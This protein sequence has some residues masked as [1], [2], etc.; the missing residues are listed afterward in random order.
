M[1][2]RSS[3]RP[4]R[5]A[6]ARSSQKK[7]GPCSGLADRARIIDL[8]DALMRG[9]VAAALD[10]LAEQYRSGADPAVILQELAA[11]THLVTR[12]K[13][14]SGAAED[15]ALSPEERD[16]GREFASKLSLRILS[17]AWQMLLKGI[18]EAQEAARPLAAA[19]MVLVRVAHAADLPTP[20]EALRQLREAGTRPGTAPRCAHRIRLLRARAPGRPRH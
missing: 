15:P 17:R 6:Q 12:I 2:S 11:F 16:R 13:L 20:D 5:T 14:A 19:D 4:R 1:H 18:A 7:S 10:E 8:F 3:I 9:D